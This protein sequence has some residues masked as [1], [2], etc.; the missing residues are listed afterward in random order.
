MTEQDYSK[1]ADLLYPDSRDITFYLEKYRPRTTKGEV[2]RL[3]PSPTGY[4]HVG[5]VYQ[6]LIHRCYLGLPTVYIICALRIQITSENL[7]MQAI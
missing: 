6:A 2:T 7:K 1:L 5:Q 3:A 4:L